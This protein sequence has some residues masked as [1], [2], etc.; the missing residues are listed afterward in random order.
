MSP[1]DFFTLYRLA[2]ARKLSENDYRAFQL[3]QARLVADYLRRRGFS[4]AGRRLLD[5]G[6]GIGGYSEE[7]ARRGARVVSVDLAPPLSWRAAG[8]APVRASAL[9]V[10]LAGRSADLVFCASLIEHVEDPALLLEE[11]ARV[12]RPGGLVYVSFPPYWSPVG[13]HEFSPFHYLGERV[14]LRLAR[15]RAEPPA[16]VHRVQDAP[17]EPRSFARLY[18]GWGLYRMTLRRMGRLLASAPFERL[19]VSTRYLPFSFVRWPLIGELLTWHAQF[20]L[21]RR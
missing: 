20:L 9:A 8:V 11:I 3:F 17:E 15:R 4:F 13:G 12:A 2:R 5:L 19:E 21:R 10:P 16:W 7:F 1:K 18:R 14:A 6:S